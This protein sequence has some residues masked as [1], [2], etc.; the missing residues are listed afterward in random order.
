MVGT[1]CL[2]TKQSNKPP[3]FQMY[4]TLYLLGKKKKKEEKEEKVI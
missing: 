3:W 2:I 1:V 4:F